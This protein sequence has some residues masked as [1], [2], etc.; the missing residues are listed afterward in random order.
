MSESYGAKIIEKHI[1]QLDYFI[2]QDEREIV[3][4]EASLAAKRRVLAESKQSLADSEEAL[5]KLRA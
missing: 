1:K 4:L 2:S 5:W 3:D